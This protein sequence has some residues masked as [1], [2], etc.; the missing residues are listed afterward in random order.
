MGNFN[1]VKIF[2]GLS[3]DKFN[4]INVSNHHLNVLIWNGQFLLFYDKCFIYPLNAFF[5]LN[6]NVYF[7]CGNPIDFFVTFCFIFFDFGLN[8]LE[9]FLFCIIWLLAFIRNGDLFWLSNYFFISLNLNSWLIVIIVARWT[10]KL[11]FS[12]FPKLFF[13]LNFLLKILLVLLMK[14]LL[15]SHLRNRWHYYFLLYFDL[16]HRLLFYLLLF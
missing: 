12:Y 1:L 6:N 13:P 5:S 4:F 7:D 2:G 16:R 10:S 3:E 15:L 8:F 14:F 9:L 11:L